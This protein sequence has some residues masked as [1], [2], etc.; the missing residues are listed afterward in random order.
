MS[1]VDTLVSA[2]RTVSRKDEHDRRWLPRAA[3]PK[4]GCRWLHDVDG[5]LIC[6]WERLPEGIAAAK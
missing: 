1:D 6:V 2:T 4:L 5:H 3:L